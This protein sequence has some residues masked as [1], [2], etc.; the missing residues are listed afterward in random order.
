MKLSVLER[1]V[2]ANIFRMREKQEN[3]PDW[4]VI[5]EV[6]ER[7]YEAE[8]DQHMVDSDPLTETDCKKV[9]DILF[10]FRA[11]NRHGSKRRFAG[12]DGNDR[13]EGRYIGYVRHLWKQKAFEES[14]HGKNDGGNSHM[15]MMPTY[16]RMLAAYQADP[17][18][19]KA[20]EDAWVHPD[21]RE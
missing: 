19:I 9:S 6:F 3:D 10:M 8:Y 1:T 12:F 7:G 5:A 2:L 16:A 14:N 18:N 20:I 4:G 17:K 21:H 11:L 13:T 15:P